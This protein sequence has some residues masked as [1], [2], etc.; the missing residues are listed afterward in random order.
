MHAVEVGTLAL[1][2]R[3]LAHGRISDPKAAGGNAARLVRGDWVGGVL[4]VHAVDGI[5]AVL[6]KHVH[7]QGLAPV[8]HIGDVKVVDAIFLFVLH[9][10]LHQLP[11]GC[12]AG[13]AA[14]CG[15]AGNEVGAV[16]ASHRRHVSFA[17]EA[18][19]VRK[20]CQGHSSRS[21]TTV[22]VIRVAHIDAAAEGGRLGDVDDLG[23]KELLVVQN[24]H[25]GR[26]GDVHV[27]EEAHGIRAVVLKD[28]VQ[29]WSRLR[30]RGLRT[31]VGADLG[32]VLQRLHQV[33]GIPG[34]AASR[35]S[36]DL[37]VRCCC[38]RCSTGAMASHKHQGC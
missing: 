1:T 8:E 22:P 28:E 2:L 4:A 20:V 32:R 33:R 9:R 34:V 13:R 36:A 7:V 30:R 14:G 29:L 35:S 15:L 3:P 12:V 31:T 37:R 18:H 24:E 11:G 16:A 27:P 38:C 21:H 5:E 25:A 10:E 26:A 6:V 19:D 23:A 17:D